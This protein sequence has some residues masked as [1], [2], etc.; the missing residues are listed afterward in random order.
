M[1]V[2]HELIM[3]LDI[4]KTALDVY[5]SGRYDPDLSSSQ[6][7]NER[8]RLVDKIFANV[9]QTNSHMLHI[10]DLEKVKETLVAKVRTQLPEKVQEIGNDDA[11]RGAITQKYQD[12]AESILDDF[13]Y[14]LWQAFGIAMTGGYFDNLLTVNQIALNIFKE[15]QV[16]AERMSVNLLPSE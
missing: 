1:E 5:F 10:T 13:R 15:Y 9:L 11:F 4:I 8:L 14:N 12:R 6:R 3:Q 16:L 2:L 7:R